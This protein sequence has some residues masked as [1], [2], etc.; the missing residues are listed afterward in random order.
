MGLKRSIFPTST[1][2]PLLTAYNRIRGRY[3]RFRQPRALRS[4]GGSAPLVSIRTRPIVVIRN[5]TNRVLRDH[6]IGILKRNHRVDIAGIGD[7]ATDR[8]RKDSIS[9]SGAIK[10]NRPD[11]NKSGLNI[12]ACFVRIN[13]DKRSPAPYCFRPKINIDGSGHRS[14]MRCGGTTV[15]HCP[16]FNQQVQQLRI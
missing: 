10:G 8:G 1:R 14:D 2:Y 4:E 11:L 3:R 12:T 5:G 15:R 16:E 13:I 9:T 7:T 6:A